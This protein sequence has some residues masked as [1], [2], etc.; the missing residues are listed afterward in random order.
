MECLSVFFFLITPGI[1]EAD[2]PYIK[3]IQLFFK[4]SLEANEYK[5]L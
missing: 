1:K 5:Q 2:D 3:G 4:S